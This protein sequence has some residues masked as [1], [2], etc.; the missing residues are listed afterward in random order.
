MFEPDAFIVR[1]EI[2]LV[3]IEPAISRTLELP[4]T[5][6]LAQL[7]EVIQA[8]FGWTDSHL[9][10]FNIG[11]LIYGA[12]EFDE[13]GADSSR[14][15]EA[16]DVRFFDFRFT[17]SLIV[18]FY[19]YDFGDGWKLALSLTRHPREDGAA[20][21]RCIAGTRAG[22]PDDS[23]GP[24]GYADFVSA[25]GDR[26]HEDHKQVRQWVGRGFNPERFDLAKTNKAIASALRRSRGGY[27]FRREA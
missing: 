26:L 19:E 22:P 8:A 6:N 11:G 16:S 12:P 21:P 20:Y 17:Y 24:H 3:G 18:F 4:M 2:H 27:R 25:W 9:H 13:G 5:L 23:G 15:F 14:T 7:H 1:A 10:E